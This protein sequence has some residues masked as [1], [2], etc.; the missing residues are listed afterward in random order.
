MRIQVCLDIL[1][2]AWTPA[3]TLHSVC[4][5]ILALLSSPEADSPL[6][7]DA[8]SS[9]FHPLVGSL[10]TC[11]CQEI[12][13]AATTSAAT[14]PWRA[15]T[16]GC[17]PPPTHPGR[18]SDIVHR[19]AMPALSLEFVSRNQ[20]ARAR[21]PEAHRRCPHAR[22]SQRRTSSAAGLAGARRIRLKRWRG[23][24]MPAGRTRARR[25]PPSNRA[26]PGPRKHAGAPRGA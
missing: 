15:C 23:M 6:N 3:W 7:C 12:F 19:S 4:R 11:S 10:T 24:P 13:C 16:R 9:H 14:I 25:R 20:E 2:T 8:G 5:A 21:T 1:K 17:T 22:P 18:V 26:F